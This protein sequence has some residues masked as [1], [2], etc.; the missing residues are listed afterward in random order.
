MVEVIEVKTMTLIL[1]FLVMILVGGGLYY[2]V[3]NPYTT[4]YSHMP[5]MMHQSLF[6]GTVF[7][8][9]LLVLFVMAGIGVLLWKQSQHT[10][11]L[12]TLHKRLVEGHITTQQYY[13]IKQLLQRK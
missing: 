4:L 3:F 6:G 2:W 8:G 10:T 12:Q 13:E 1:I 7:I 5:Y 11:P 9:T